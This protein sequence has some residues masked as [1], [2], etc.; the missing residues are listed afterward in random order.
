[1]ADEGAD[2][3]SSAELLKLFQIICSP[4]DRRYLNLLRHR[5]RVCRNFCRVS[6]SYPVSSGILPDVTASL[7]RRKNESFP[8]QTQSSSE[9]RQAK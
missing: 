5:L 9:A 2:L 1:M 3:N 4:E 8:I 7:L 6:G